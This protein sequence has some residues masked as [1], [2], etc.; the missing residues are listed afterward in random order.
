MSLLRFTL[1]VAARN[2]FILPI[3]HIAGVEND[4]ADALSRGE[5]ERFRRLAPHAAT[6]PCQVPGSLS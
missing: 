3:R 2:N 4:I 1:K 5:L 6:A